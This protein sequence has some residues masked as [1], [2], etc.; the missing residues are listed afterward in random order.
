MGALRGSNIGE[1]KPGKIIFE[2]VHVWE[3]PLP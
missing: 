3:D 2:R 1:G